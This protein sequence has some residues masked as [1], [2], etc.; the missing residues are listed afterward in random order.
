MFKDKLKYIS[1]FLIFEMI[2]LSTLLYNRSNQEVLIRE[3]ELKSLELKFENRKVLY[4][5]LANLI[6]TNLIYRDKVIKILDLANR[7][8]FEE[9]ENLRDILKS[10]FI[11]NYE[12]SLKFKFKQFHFH[13]ADGES[14]FR[15]HREDVYG[16]RVFDFRDSIRVANR[17][18]VEVRGVEVGKH[19]FSYRHIF[20]IIQAG[21]VIATVELATPLSNLIHHI[22]TQCNFHIHLLLKKSV[23]YQKNFDYQFKNYSVSKLSSDYLIEKNR[24]LNTLNLKHNRDFGG[25]SEEITQK[26][27]SKIYQNLTL[28]LKKGESFTKVIPIDSNIY[29]ASFLPIYSISEKEIGYLVSYSNSEDLKDTQKRFFMILLL[30]TILNLIAIIYLYKI[31]KV[32]ELLQ[33]QAILEDAK[34]EFEAIFN[35]AN[36]GIVLVKL[37]SLE[38]DLANQK[39]LNML[40]FT[41]KSFRGVR[42]YDIHPDEVLDSILNQLSNLKSNSSSDMLYFRDIPV[43][44]STKEIFYA[45]I[46]TSKPIYLNG[47]KYI[48]AI[49]RDTTDRKILED[50]LKSLNRN[51]KEKIDMEVDRSREKDRVMFQQS[52]YAQMGEM[53]SMIA[54]QWRQPLN[55]ISSYAIDLEL[56]LSLDDLSSKNILENSRY[57]Q[58][59]AQIMS[60]I[61]DDFMNFFKP[62]QKREEFYLIEIVEDIKSLVRA[63]FKNR[64]IELIYDIDKN[65]KLRDF[66]KEIEHVIINFLTNSRDAFDNRDIEGKFIKI[67]AKELYNK[68]IITVTDNAGGIDESIID[69]VFDPYFTTKEQGKGTGI[70]LYMSKTII[71]KSFNG[72]I[73]AKNIKSGVSFTISI[74]K[75]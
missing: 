51:L 66:K 35:S 37:E 10:E 67:E 13:L 57:I 18:R 22:N 47:S 53:L 41:P 48:V 5:D 70:G 36:D 60:K 74:P 32:K 19:Y 46:T 12:K 1:I 39:M 65:L 9:R 38:F 4:S 68:I 20:P 55:A 75:R 25:V 8:N 24:F 11:E 62:E 72:A 59:Q 2:I 43:K 61:V 17:D 31:S 21:E 50:E 34:S 14:F 64:N 73:S 42:V 45:D 7:S 33:T 29:I 44:K 23:V 54:H 15:F 56:K 40:E 63:Q 71:E 30:L 69:R 27:D 6:F 3:Q 16:D 52:K 28:K 49:F 58:E 26:I